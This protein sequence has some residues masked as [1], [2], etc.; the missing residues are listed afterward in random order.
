MKKVTSRV[1][2]VF[3]TLCTV[4]LLLLLWGFAFFIGGFIVFTVA[5]IATIYLLFVWGT[6]CKIAT[7]TKF[8]VKESDIPE[9]VKDFFK[10]SSNISYD[11]Y[12]FDYDDLPFGYNVRR[13]D[14]DQNFK[15]T[16]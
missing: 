15:K 12:D 2:V 13:E 5:I 11:I 4:A 16:K 7:E 10:N 9:E 1:H 14:N 8:S 6:I 3:L